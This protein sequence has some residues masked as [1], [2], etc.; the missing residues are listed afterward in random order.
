M[1][2]CRGCPLC[3][4][5]SA[6]RN[7]QGTFDSG[8][9]QLKIIQNGDLVC[10][11][12]ITIFLPPFWSPFIQINCRSPKKGRG[13]IIWGFRP[14]L[15]FGK[16]IHYTLASHIAGGTPSAAPNPQVGA[17]RETIGVKFSLFSTVLK[18]ICSFWAW[19]SARTAARNSS[20]GA[21]AGV[22]YSHFLISL[23]AVTARNT[24]SRVLHPR[25]PHRCPTH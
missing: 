11:E 20:R 5:I 23:F 4:M 2:P 18:V 3:K 13:T 8:P 10:T 22:P 14:S 16:G 6:H 7:E 9:N 24:K 25:P 1:H 21:Q 12:V 19:G 15:P 17:L